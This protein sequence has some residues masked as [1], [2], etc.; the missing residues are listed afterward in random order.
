MGSTLSDCSGPDT[1]EL[2]SDV[3][4]EH[5]STSSN[6]MLSPP[7]KSLSQRSSYDG[8]E[9]SSCTTTE[10]SDSML[11]SVYDDPAGPG[12]PVQI[13]DWSVWH[14][15]YKARLGLFGKDGTDVC[16][17]P[18][19]FGDTPISIMT[20][21]SG[22]DAAVYALRKLVGP[23]NVE[24]IASIDSCKHACTFIAANVPPHH[25]YCCDLSKALNGPASCI[26]P[27]CVA[28]D[29]CTA[30]VSANPDLFVGGFPCK[31]F[32]IC[33]PRRWDRNVWKHKDAQPFKTI[34]EY[35]QDPTHH[36]PAV[37]ILENVD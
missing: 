17:Y 26:S 36:K 15:V 34:S 32:S 23:L 29:D 14:F 7:A 28:G 8:D 27:T 24:H 3:A 18:D 37:C 25:L 35:L 30:A 19:A 5:Q 12:D 6:S 4:S 2:G 33:N 9:S 13:A 31:P 21:C 16:D 10:C 22:T 11:G 20:V 1:F